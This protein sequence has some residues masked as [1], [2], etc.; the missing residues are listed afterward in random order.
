MFTLSRTQ[1]FQ[2]SLVKTLVSLLCCSLTPHS[3]TLW[4]SIIGRF[5]CPYEEFLS[6]GR[7]HSNERGWPGLD[8]ELNEDAPGI[9]C[10]TSVCSISVILGYY[11]KTF[12]CIAQGLPDGCVTTDVIVRKLWIWF[13]DQ[14]KGCFNNV[15]RCVYLTVIETIDALMQVIIQVLIWQQW[16]MHLRPGCCISSQVSVLQLTL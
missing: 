10:Y 15:K 14:A 7:Q 6:K 2:S 3:L 13:D 5:G 16:E 1:K 8:M 4:T 11:T 12:I 9:L